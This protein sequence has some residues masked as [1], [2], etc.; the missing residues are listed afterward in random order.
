VSY[1]HYVKTD[2]PINKITFEEFVRLY[3]NHRPAIR[4]TVRQIK[5]V[6]CAL[7]PQCSKEHR[8]M[9]DPTLTR[10]Q[11][12]HILLGQEISGVSK[13]DHKLLGIYLFIINE[14]RPD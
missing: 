7:I 11:F 2:E 12:I 14:F 3:V 4:F 10:E 9:E 6:F 8:I 13:E 1:K 5:K